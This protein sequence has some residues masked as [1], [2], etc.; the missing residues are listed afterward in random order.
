MQN[1][2]KPVQKD[3]VSENIF[4]E[5]AEDFILPDYLPEIRRVLR[6][7]TRLIKGESFVSGGKADFEGSVLYTLFY[8]DSDEVLTTVPLESRYS[9]EA[10]LGAQVPSFVYSTETVEGVNMR[11]SGPRRLSIR[12]KIRSAVH[13]V[14]EE[15]LQKELSSLLPEGC[16]TVECLEKRIS[17]LHTAF[18]R[19]EATES[20]TEFTLEGKDCEGLRPFYASADI[21][22]ERASAENGH[23]F[24]RGSALIKVLL[25]DGEDVITLCRR[26][27]FEDAMIA[28]CREGDGVTA[29]GTCHAVNVSLAQSGADATVSVSA[30]HSF[31][32]VAERNEQASVLCDAYATEKLLTVN[33]KPLY[34][35]AY[36]DGFMGNFTV[37]GECELAEGTSVPL[38]SFTVKSAT[39][40]WEGR[41]AVISGEM[42]AELL[43]YGRGEDTEKPC[44]YAKDFV[45]PFRIEAETASGVL[46]DDRFFYRITPIECTMSA[47]NGKGYLCGEVMLS[48]RALRAEEYAVPE[49]IGFG[50]REANGANDVVIY[51]PTDKDSLW[52][53]GKA[54]GIP[55]AHLCAQNGIVLEEGASTDDTKT[56][57]GV[58]WLFAS[59]L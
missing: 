39:L 17:V 18:C 13:A 30:T 44:F 1:E 59:S 47:Q 57:D 27:P 58:A 51:Y 50:E 53:V 52:S 2:Y 23:I 10:P 46:A 3:N 15:P 24:C 14:S 43:C 20:S 19:S 41:R 8:T 11:P 28:D 37:E 25:E 42:R 16:G 21:L 22:I 12:T 34:T 4:T 48:L 31:E 54:Y 29:C 9:Y 5:C 56:L 35:T 40:S 36:A 32:A 55:T 45:F 33:K 38:S 26:V 6:L 7:E 49:S